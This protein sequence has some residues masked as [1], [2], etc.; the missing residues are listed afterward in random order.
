MGVLLNDFKKFFRVN[1]SGFK[2]DADGR[3]YRQSYPDKG[4]AIVCEFRASDQTELLPERTIGPF[5]LACLVDRDGGR[6]LVE[7]TD[8]RT[9]RTWESILEKKTRALIDLVELDTNRCEACG[10]W[11]VPVTVSDGRGAKSVRLRCPQCGKQRELS[12][13]SNLKTLFHKYLK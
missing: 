5:I 6:K 1:R 9:T 8:T 13:G 4:L 2:P 7:V 12:F 3:I 11:E 10:R